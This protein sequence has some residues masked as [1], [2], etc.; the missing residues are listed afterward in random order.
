M[1]NVVNK[2]LA[3]IVAVGPGGENLTT[4]EEDEDDELAIL[5]Q[6]LKVFQIMLFI[7]FVY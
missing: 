7:L 6:T 2:A 4:Y 3:F 1:D 5:L